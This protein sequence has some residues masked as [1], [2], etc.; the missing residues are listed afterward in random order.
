MSA[1][2]KSKSS[3]RQFQDLST[4]DVG[5]VCPNDS[6]VCTLVQDDSEKNQGFKKAVS[7]YKSRVA[8]PKSNLH[9]KSKNRK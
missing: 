5:F 7:C 6:A 3:A 9:C 2:K 8:F 1:A 4:G